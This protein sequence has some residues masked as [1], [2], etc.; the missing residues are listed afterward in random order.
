MHPVVQ[1]RFISQLPVGLQIDTD[2]QR[3]LL[4]RKITFQRPD[5]SQSHIG[6]VRFDLLQRHLLVR[7]VIIDCTLVIPT[8]LVPIISDVLAHH[9][10]RRLRMPERPLLCIKMQQWM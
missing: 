4:V 3:E 9:L 7:V 8:N 5:L 2:T 1:G 6:F 10:F